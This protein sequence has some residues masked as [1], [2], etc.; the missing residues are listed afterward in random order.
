M[1]KLFL[2]TANILEIEK[3]IQ[4]SAISGVTTNPSLIAKEQHVALGP[5]NAFDTP[6][7]QCSD[8]TQKVAKVLHDVAV[9][10]YGRNTT[11][12]LSVEVITLDPR[13]M[14]S[15]AMTLLHDLERYKAYLDVYV[16]VPLLLE[17]LPVITELARRNVNVNATAI[18]TAAQAKVAEDAGAKIVSFF[19][20]RIKDGGGDPAREIGRYTNLRTSYDRCK[21]IAGSIRKPADVLEAWEAG[22]DIVTASAKV[23]GEML[24]HP[25]TEKAVTKFAEDIA[26][27]VK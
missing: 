14:I 18:M 12:H 1:M 2:D 19:F 16:K 8:A 27:W 9:H 3:F 10:T 26:S 24:Y 23:I 5:N 6:I 22:S 21:I 20:N 7:M 15:E 17:T 11:F 4:T 13:G 25:Q